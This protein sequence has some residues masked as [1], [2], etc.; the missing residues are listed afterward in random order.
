MELNADKIVT[1]AKQIQSAVSHLEGIKIVQY[2]E[3][4]PRNGLFVEIGSYLGCSSVIMGSVANILGS[5]FIMI[6]PFYETSQAE[7]EKNL[8]DRGIKYQLMVGR[9]HDVAPQVPD[10]IDVLFIDGTH[11]Y[12]GV[13]EDCEDYLPKMKKGGIVIFHDY[14]GAQTG[15]RQAVDE[16]EGLN[17]LG[18]FDSMLIAEVV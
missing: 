2:A 7:C 9:S 15:V 5:I 10:G 14:E 1:S 11:L 18:I 6:E 13:K 8:Q 16:C 4:A 17:H 12:N 3:K